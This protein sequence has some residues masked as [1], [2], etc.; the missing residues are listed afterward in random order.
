M[1]IIYKNIEDIYV[2]R[3]PFP[4]IFEDEFLDTDFAKKIQTEIM[5]IPEEAWDRYNNP[6]EQKYTLR[7][8][9]NSHQGYKIFSK[10]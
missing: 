8:K 6:F 7:D 5:S 3:Y 4:Y 9:Y 10:N 2:N 1:P